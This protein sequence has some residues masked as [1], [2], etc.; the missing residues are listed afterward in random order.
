MENKD[1]EKIIVELLQ[2]NPGSN[3]IFLA[4]A[5]IEKINFAQNFEEVQNKKANDLYNYLGKVLENIRKDMD[6]EISKL[7]GSDVDIRIKNLAKGQ[8]IVCDKIEDIMFNYKKLN[9][10]K[11]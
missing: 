5:I 9:S 11:S 8:K 7:S 1:I 3:P 4:K 2:K 6:N 10:Y